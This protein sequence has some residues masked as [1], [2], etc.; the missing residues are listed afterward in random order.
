MRRLRS[1]RFES[2][3]GYLLPVAQMVEH[4]SPHGKGPNA[5]VG[6]C[7]QALALGGRRFES[8]REDLKYLFNGEHL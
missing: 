4:T 6:V 8:D 1:Y 2:G 3:S 5:G 7:L